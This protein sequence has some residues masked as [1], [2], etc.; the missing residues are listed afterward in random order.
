M[1]NI[2]LP[3]S[4]YLEE[5]LDSRVALEPGV[6]EIP[7]AVEEDIT[8]DEDADKHVDGDGVFARASVVVDQ[9]HQLHPPWRKI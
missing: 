9:N 6:E 2:F 1:S 3:Q 7:V 4:E 5:P 8:G